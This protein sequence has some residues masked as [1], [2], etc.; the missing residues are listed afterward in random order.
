M[1][2]WNWRGISK[3]TIFQRLLTVLFLACL[4]GIIIFLTT[5]NPFV[6]SIAIYAF[7]A[8]IGI[9]LFVVLELIYIFWRQKVQKYQLTPI[10]IQ[11]SSGVCLIVSLGIISLL[12]FNQIKSLDIISIAILTGF[13]AFYWFFVNV[14]VS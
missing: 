14:F 8:L 1:N 4:I 12:T 11:I 2:F 9:I 10:N 13:G 5:V 3:Y 6:D 7:Y